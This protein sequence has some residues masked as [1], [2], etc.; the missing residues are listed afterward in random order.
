M[1]WTVLRRDFVDGKVECR[2]G[3]KRHFIRTGTAYV[4][5]NEHGE[6]AFCGPTCAKNAEY[7]TNPNETVPDLTSKLILDELTQTKG[8]GG[9]S[10]SRQDPIKKEIQNNKNSELYLEVLYKLVPLLNLAA[11]TIDDGLNHLISLIL[12]GD[13][14][15]SIRKNF[16]HILL[17]VI[18]STKGSRYELKYLLFMYA[19]LKQIDFLFKRKNCNEFERDFL[20]S[21]QMY[22][23]RH[24]LV[25]EKQFVHINRKLQ[26][27]GRSIH[28]IGM[29]N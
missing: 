2:L 12:K 14:Q 25:S 26:V 13:S 1:A 6:I 3:V 21:C 17:D 27:F 28:F 29:E 10:G 23:M 4:I 20:Q 18:V 22:V 15:D 5:E 16:R 24:H 19:Y 7:V 8:K 11:N 9:G